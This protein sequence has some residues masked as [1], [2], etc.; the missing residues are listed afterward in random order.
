MI[1]RGRQARSG[2]YGVMGGV[3]LCEACDGEVHL[4]CS[5][6]GCKNTLGL[7]APWRLWVKNQVNN[8]LINNRLIITG[9]LHS[10]W[11]SQCHNVTIST[12][13]LLG[14]HESRVGEVLAFF[15]P[16]E[17]TVAK[18]DG[19]LE[20]NGHKKKMS[21]GEMFAFPRV[22]RARSLNHLAPLRFTV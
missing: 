20:H 9:V 4:K 5:G 7:K 1:C 8:R 10:G 14:R 2:S 17:R 15:R 18:L 11:A 13:V 12:L 3:L 22:A 6:L 19:S 21:F 16:C